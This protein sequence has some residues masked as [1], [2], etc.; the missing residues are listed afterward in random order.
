LIQQAGLVAVVG[1]L[2]L[3]T[4]SNM[5]ELRRLG[6]YPMPRRLPTVSILVPARNE[7]GNIG[8]CLRSLLAQEYPHYEVI[9]LDD[10][11]EDRTGAILAGLA[12][13][14]PRLTVL[15]GRPL[16][17]GWLGKNWACHQL[18]ERARGELLLFTDADTRHHPRALA[19][20][21][22][23]L[24]A[25][26]ADLLTAFPQQ[27][28]GSWAERLMVPGMIWTFFLFMP[29]RLAY[30]SPRPGLSVTCGQFMLFR[31]SAYKAI[32][33]HKAVR[34][35][36]VEDMML[37]RRIKEQGLRWRVLDGC[38]RVRC[39][40]YHGLREALDGFGKNLFAGFR[41][42]ISAYVL[43]WLFATVLVLEP[44]L[45]L[46]LWWAGVP[47]AGFSP[48]LAATAVGAMLL[49]VG[50][51]YPRFRFP[52]YLALIYPLTLLICIGIAAYSL[53]LALTGRSYW[54]GRQI[55]RPRIRWW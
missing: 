9:A 28:T 3:I 16:P 38:P 26:Q 6:G 24:E 52:A 5:H 45:V 30:R 39:R 34:Q 32:G 49:L 19:D 8:A 36:V 10:N 1:G 33:G 7:E 14:H 50:I 40:M 53:G 47:L 11:S 2:T 18:A 48:A 12:A 37:G 17:A 51:S 54:K 15:Q 46:A 43:G 23:A 25:E 29:L 44:L 41:Y 4:L 20:A 42:N 27:E 35:D 22:A 31:R 21:V 13:E 55:G